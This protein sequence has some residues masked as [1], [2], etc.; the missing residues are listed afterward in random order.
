MNVLFV[1]AHQDDEF[2]ASVPLVRH[3]RAGD[4][5]HCVYLTNGETPVATGAVRN[6]EALR[7]LQSLG[8]SKA[9]ISFIGTDFAIPDGGLC[10][11]L[12]DADRALAA[13]VIS[14]LDGAIDALYLLG[15]EGG[16]HDHDAA[17]LLGLALARD[18][19]LLERTR[20]LP[21]YHGQGVPGK[22]FRT[23]VPLRGRSGEVLRLTIGEGL[24]AAS[25]AR[26]Y[27]SQRKTWIG[28]FPEAFVRYVLLRRAYL[29]RVDL[30]AI[31]LRPHAGRLLYER[32]GRMSYE[33]FRSTVSSFVA[34]RLPKLQH[35]G[36]GTAGPRTKGS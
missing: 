29:L 25:L 4:A 9:N 27:P 17:H 32:M 18:R 24:R 8:V 7:A 6:T 30:S 33:R 3:V 21:L 10:E 1:F 31:E 13:Y 12:A 19:G 15:W 36:R 35:P 26:F 20:Q 16:H 28:L 2:S 23:L 5:V 14:R 34:E 11:R 22:L